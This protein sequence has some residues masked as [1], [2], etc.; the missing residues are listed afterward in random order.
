MWRLNNLLL[1]IPQAKEEIKN[2]IL[3]QLK[4]KK[5]HIKMN[6]MNKSSFKR[7]IYSD[8]CLC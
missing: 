5:Q 8:K 6:K 4:M 3:R 7:E 2:C 1:N